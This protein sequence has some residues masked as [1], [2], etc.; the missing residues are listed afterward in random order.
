MFCQDMVHCIFL[1]RNPD[2]DPTRFNVQLP[3]YES[4]WEAQTAAEC[5]HLLQ[6][7]PV[8]MH[9]STAMKMLTSWPDTETPLFE[10]SGFGMHVLVNG[11]SPKQ[12]VLC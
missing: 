6:S 4:C 11:M 3:S 12:S 7:L 9:V 10:A 1:G 5:L 2:L 8:P